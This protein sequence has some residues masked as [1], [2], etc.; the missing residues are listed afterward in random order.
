M[1]RSIFFV[2]VSVGRTVPNLD[3]VGLAF[4]EMGISLTE[5]EEYI[6]Y[7]DPMPFALDVPRFPV[8]KQTMLHFP[9]PNSKE[10][11]NRE[12]HIHEHLPPQ[13]PKWDG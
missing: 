5:L 11:Q 12:E 3:D 13:H 1:L 7:V 4:Q 9:C 6:T 10:L 8:P 2:Y